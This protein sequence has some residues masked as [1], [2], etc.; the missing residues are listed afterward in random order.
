MCV[1]DFEIKENIN[2][3]GVMDKL[4]SCPICPACGSKKFDRL[5]ER[6]TVVRCIKC[7]KELTI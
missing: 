1:I 7:G 3:D 6:D 5:K 2:M 4:R